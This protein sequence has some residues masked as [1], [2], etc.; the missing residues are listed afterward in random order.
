MV[1]LCVF[2]REFAIGD[3]LAGLWLMC[4][5]EL[6]YIALDEPHEDNYYILVNVRV[7]TDFF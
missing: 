2:V 6:F 3:F 4:N 5:Y 1:A 7:S